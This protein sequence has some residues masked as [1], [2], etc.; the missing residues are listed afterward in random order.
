MPIF[1][2]KKSLYLFGV[3]FGLTPLLAQKK[4]DAKAVIT[5]NTETKKEDSLPLGAFK[6]RS[7]GPAV[8]SGRVVD[9]A[10]NPKNHSEYYVATAAGGVWKTVNHGVMYEPIFD[11]EGSYSIGCVTIDPNNTNVVWVGS[12]ENNNQRAA[13]YGDGV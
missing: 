4:K 2:L 5:S 8:T 10:I 1:S 12:G 6:L 11:G 13:N 3:V 9:M 7:I